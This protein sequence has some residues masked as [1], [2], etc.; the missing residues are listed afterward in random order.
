M[1]W[2]REYQGNDGND[3][4]MHEGMQMVPINADNTRD[5]HVSRRLFFE[6]RNSEG[7]MV[8]ILGI[9]SLDGRFVPH[10]DEAVW[11]KGRVKG[12]RQNGMLRKDF[13]SCARA[14]TNDTG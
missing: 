13:P 7:I 12:Q 9:R 11:A 6:C 2:S 3:E 4:R 1:L 14:R 5:H 8:N 10:N